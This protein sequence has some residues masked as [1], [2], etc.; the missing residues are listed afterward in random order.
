MLSSSCE[1]FSHHLNKPREACWILRGRL[2]QTSQLWPWTWETPQERA[3]E[4][5]SDHWVCQTKLSQPSK[6]SKATIY[7]FKPL[8]LGVV[9]YPA[10]ANLYISNPTVGVRYQTCHLEGGLNASR[11]EVMSPAVKNWFPLTPGAL[12]T[13]KLTLIAG[14][15]DCPREE[16]GKVRETEEIPGLLQEFP[17]SMETLRHFLNL[18][19][20]L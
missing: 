7:C 17:D 6:L 19:L 3:A 13:G 9:C 15:V 12:G 16:S 14:S 2:P 18:P 1:L 5:G 11:A 4:P 8:S 10:K 20:D